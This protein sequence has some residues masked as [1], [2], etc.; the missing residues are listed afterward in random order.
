MTP[1]VMGSGCDFRTVPATVKQTKRHERNMKNILRPVTVS[2]RPGERQARG[3]GKTPS[4]DE[5]KSGDLS[6]PRM[7]ADP[8]G[9]RSGI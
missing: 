7:D 2:S 8:W 9:W 1:A 6:V 3:Y 5:A 4:E